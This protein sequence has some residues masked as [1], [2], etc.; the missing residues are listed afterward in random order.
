MRN[1]S[2]SDLL[3]LVPEA[4]DWRLDW[5]AIRALWPELQA[6]DAC[7]Q[8]P[9]H[10]GEGDVG[11]HTR[12]VLEALI[13]DPDW[14]ALPQADR[15]L[16]FWTAVLH[17]VGKPGTT[18]TEDGRIKAPGHSRRGSLMARTLL[19]EVEVPFHWREALCGLIAC[20]QVPFWLIEREDPAREAIRLSWRCRP[21]LL[22]LH[23]R[24]DARGRIAEDVANIVTNSDLAREA[25]L[26]QDCLTTPFAFANDESRVAFFEREDRDPHFAA[27]EDPKCTVTLMSGLPGS[28][29]DT[30]IAANM[31]DLPVI[32]LDALRDEM[33]VSPTAN[34]GP[35]ID[36][37][38]ERAKEHLRAGRDFV[39]NAT[40]VTRQVRAK[41]LSLARAYGARVEIVYLEVPPARLSRQN[42]DREAVVPQDVLDNLVRKLEPPEAW[43]AHRIHY[44]LPEAAQAA[45]A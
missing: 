39:W 1:L 11:T 34:Q 14:R 24:A 16:L 38:R 30:W 5:P 3:T 36:A 29:K 18:V 44:V 40:N 21:D 2:F 7:P 35:V 28:G 9:V 32:S 12:M 41:P 6:L 27:F 25:F 19:R 20:H 4:P 17:D 15:E 13:A 31:G 22:C 42:R 8:D 33:R 37:A 43:E 45:P 26:E 10:H 23:A